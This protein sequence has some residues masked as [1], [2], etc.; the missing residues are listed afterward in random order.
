MML[1]GFGGGTGME[2]EMDG[3]YQAS[4]GQAGMELDDVPEIPLLDGSVRYGV[5]GDG[6]MKSRRNSMMEKIDLS[7]SPFMTPVDGQEEWNGERRVG[8]LLWS[9][10][11]FFYSK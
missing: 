10:N 11:Y 4:W 8:G 2:I 1:D 7:S 9:A 3:D 6:G 5:A